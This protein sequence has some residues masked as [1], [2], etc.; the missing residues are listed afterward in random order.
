MKIKRKTLDRLKKQFFI[1]LGIA[2][3]GL[4]WYLYWVSAIFTIT[5]YR[6]SGVED[7]NVALLTEELSGS[8]RGFRYFVIPNNK[9][10][11]YNSAL[12]TEKVIGVIPDTKSVAIR[13]IGLHTVRVSVTKHTPL[14]K[15]DATTGVSEEGILFKTGK[16]LENY[17]TL[18]IASSTQKTI[19]TSGIIFSQLEGVN[20]ELLLKLRE[21]EN[22]ISSVIFPVSVVTIDIFGDV[23]FIDKR[24]V[25]KV[26]ITK[27]MDTKKGWATLLSAIDTDPLKTKLADTNQTLE[28]LDVRFGNKVF[29]KFINMPFQASNDPDILED[30]ESPAS[31]TP[32][33]PE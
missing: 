22:K 10:L 14:F 7:E 19:T 11:S 17:P 3:L 30:H 31:T 20:S 25:S 26:L 12:I 1:L 33:T 13:P 2:T 9:V 15:V 23:A 6:L 28:Y 27:D 5:S 21:F 8:N 18:A 24:G 32:S 4:V 16:G 29:Y